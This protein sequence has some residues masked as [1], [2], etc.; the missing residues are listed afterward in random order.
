RRCRC[1]RCAPSIYDLTQA[2]VSN[3]LP[4]LERIVSLMPNGGLI[5]L[6]TT[7]PGREGQINGRAAQY[8]RATNAAH[9]KPDVRR[10]R[11]EALPLR[12]CGDKRSSPLAGVN[13][14]AAIRSMRNSQQ[15]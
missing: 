9:E 14:G 15:R 2:V 1:G 7:T 12:H 3:H 6:S 11:A 13:V 4:A 5:P 8:G 10:M